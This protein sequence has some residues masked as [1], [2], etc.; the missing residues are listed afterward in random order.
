MMFLA[1]VLPG[2]A[3]QVYSLTDMLC[4]APRS[5]TFCSYR[6]GACAI[7]YTRAEAVMAAR[8]RLELAKAPRPVLRVSV[9]Q[10]GAW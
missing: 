5:W 2:V 6:R 8:D 7:G 9:Q 4:A 10:R 1:R 3:P